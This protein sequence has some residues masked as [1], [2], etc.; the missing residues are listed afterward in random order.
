MS[1]KPNETTSRK[2]RRNPHHVLK[3]I[4]VV[5]MIIATFGVVRVTSG[6]VC[7]RR[8]SDTRST[9]E[10]LRASCGVHVP[11]AG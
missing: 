6:D 5:G 10:W 3:V 2:Q 8:V 7:I 1:S 9:P 4:G 11:A